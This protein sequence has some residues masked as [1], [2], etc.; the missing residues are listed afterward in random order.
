MK[1]LL[2]VVGLL[3][4]A[5][6]A[7]GQKEGAEKEALDAYQKAVDAWIKGDMEAIDK[8]LHD[9]YISTAP[10]GEVGDKAKT[11]EM[12]KSGDVKVDSIDTTDLRA[13]AYGDTAVVTGRGRM[14]AKYQGEEIDLDYRFTEVYV[15]K[16]GAWKAVAS[17]VTSVP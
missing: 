7:L 14:K 15:K 6:L 1:R 2:V 11:M 13:R 16:D 17:H 9:D 3:A 10:G 4:L 5:P 12:A 8:S